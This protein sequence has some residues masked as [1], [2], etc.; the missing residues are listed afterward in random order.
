MASIPVVVLVSDPF[1]HL[2]K[3]FAYLFNIYWSEQ[4]PVILAGYSP[5]SG[6]LPANFTW[7]KIAD[8][9]YPKNMYSDGMIKL[10]QDFPERHFVLM[11][12]DY[13]LTR[14]VD[15]RGVEA[16]AEYCRQ[17][18]GVLRC[19]LTTD[20]LYNGKMK[21][22]GESWGCYDIIE[23]P[24]G[25]EY[26]M[27]FQTGIWNRDLLMRLLVPGKSPWEVEIHTSPPENMRVIGTRQNPVRY[28][29]LMLKGQV[30]DTELDKIPGQHREKVA[31]MIEK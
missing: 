25:S 6:P 27:S 15:H 19:D 22:Y 30:Q 9:P 2:V 18:P 26:Q 10:F 31:E 20:R 13:F 28:A 8:F 16:M 29:N 7:K 5:P 23:S 4:Q 21:D 12:E 17:H 3:P 1:L 11:L 24:H 14:T